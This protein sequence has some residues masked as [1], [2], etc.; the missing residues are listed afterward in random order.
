[1]AVHSSR[2]L[3]DCQLALPVQR[4]TH[5]E[6]QIV[7]AWCP[8]EDFAQTVGAGNQHRRIT[9]TSWFLDHDQVLAADPLDCLDHLAHA[10]AVTVTAMECQWLAV[11]ATMVQR[12]KMGRCKI[13]DVNA[14]TDAGAVRDVVVGTKERQ[15]WPFSDGMFTG[16]LEQQNCL[17]SRP[18]DAALRIAAGDIELAQYHVLHRTSRAKIT[19]HGFGHQLGGPMVWTAIK[20]SPQLGTRYAANR[21][22]SP[23]DCQEESSFTPMQGKAARKAASAAQVPH[24]R[25]APARLTNWQ[26]PGGAG[27]LL[28]QTRG[29][30]VSCTAADV[31]YD[32]SKSSGNGSFCQGLHVTLMVRI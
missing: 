26:V 15:T 30:Q 25:V 27:L 2:G 10:A 16:H 3:H 22:R 8:A 14:V 6:I 17:G 31:S 23:P 21:T 28:N 13:L 12:V 4:R 11:C 19:Q 20:S 18:S 24:E 9:G 29:W 5:D 32:R 7:M 1:M